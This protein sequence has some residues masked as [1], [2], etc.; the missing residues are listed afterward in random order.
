MKK[1]DNKKTVLTY[2]DF[3]FE[4]SDIVSDRFD[5]WRATKTKNK[6]TGKETDSRKLVG[7]GYK[8]AEAIQKVIET[9]MGERSDVTD[10]KSYVQEYRKATREVENA[11]K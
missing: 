8:F 11:L 9:E 2:K 1:T 3:I 10:L 4:A 5:L 6:K 7:Y